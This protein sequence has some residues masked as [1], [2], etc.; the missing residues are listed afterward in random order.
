[1]FFDRPD[2]GERALLVHCEF[3]A[4]LAR[5]SDSELRDTD[6]VAVPLLPCADEFYELAQSAGVE[7]LVLVTARRKLPTPKF[8]PGKGKV[9]EISA[10]VV[11]HQIEV[12]L[13]NHSLSPSQERNLEQEFKCQ[14]LDRAGLPPRPLLT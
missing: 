7:P 2:S 13:F 14:V 3:S 5:H 4:P 11:E 12:V 9:A 8:F 6:A 1:M 10:L